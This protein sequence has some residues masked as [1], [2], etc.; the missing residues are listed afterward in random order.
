MWPRKRRLTSRPAVVAAAEA[1]LEGRVL[2]H[3]RQQGYAVPPWAL[4]NTLAHAPVER[5]RVLAETPE[6]KHPSDL[7]A[8]LGRLAVDILTLGPEPAAVRAVQRELLV[9]V[10][11]VLLSCDCPPGVTLGELETL[12][13]R[14]L[15]VR[16]GHVGPNEG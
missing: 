10:E 9:Q 7:D 12:L 8:A 3:S 11:L 5:L 4:V 1:L 15:A 13:G 14:M 6:L 2:D 16:R